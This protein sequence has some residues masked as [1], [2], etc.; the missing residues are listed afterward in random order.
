MAISDMRS[1]RLDYS[2]WVIHF[3][4]DRDPEVDT[5]H[6]GE[7][8]VCLEPDAGAFAVLK[9]VLYEGV[10]RA[11]LSVRDGRPTVFGGRPVVCFTEM[12]LR[13]LLRYAESRPANRVG[14]YGIGLLKREVFMAGGRP[15]IYGLSGGLRYQDAPRR[16]LADAVLPR[17]EQY[18][19]V[20]YDPV[21][22]SIDWTHE[23]EWRWCADSERPDH[24]A[25]VENSLR[26]GI[27]VPALR[28]FSPPEEGGCFTEAAII[29]QDAEEADEIAANLV[30]MSDQGSTDFGLSFCTDVLE[31]VRIVV[32]DE[33][34]KHAA[35]GDL[36]V[37][38]LESIPEACRFPLRREPVDE[39]LLARVA[40]AVAEASVRAKEAFAKYLE[41]HSADW[42]R[43][44]AAFVWVVATDGRSAVTRALLGQ[45]LASPDWKGDEYTVRVDLG[46]P[47][48]EWAPKNAAA[49]AAVG[50]LREALAQDGPDGPLVRVA[51]N[52]PRAADWELST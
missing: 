18:R 5:D 10:L 6:E 4:R 14:T 17:Q 32:M 31:K 52:P 47:V 50:Y 9:N 1:N 21:D 25:Y 48:Q 12:P 8:P 36:S 43:D 27:E 11:G 24:I 49:E 38:K 51:P 26:M 40:D 34:K 45:G 16:V 30:R 33:V 28:L 44:G 22:R 46:A 35:A 37:G 15:A 19:L 42:Q 13:E 3:L 39:E 20:S 29:V 41:E 23:R 2:E 7:S